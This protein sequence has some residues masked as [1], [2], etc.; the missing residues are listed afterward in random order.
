MVLNEKTCFFLQR[1]A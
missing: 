1:M